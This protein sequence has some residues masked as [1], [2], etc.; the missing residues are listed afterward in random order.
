MPEVTG[1]LLYDE[2]FYIKLLNRWKDTY[3][4]IQKINDL[5]F[6]FAAMKTKQEFYKMG[7]IALI[8]R[9]GGQ[10]EMIAHINDAQRRGDLS[11][12]QAFDLRKAVNDACTSKEGLTAPNEA[13]KELD[14]KVL[15]AVRF[16]R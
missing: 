10:L 9:A 3:K 6:N 5:T 4:E 12:K 14:K 13:I 8:E 16:Y 11:K 2:A 15:E 7:L 1:G